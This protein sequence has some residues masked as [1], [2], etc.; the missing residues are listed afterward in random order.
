MITN[1]LWRLKFNK[2]QP[3]FHNPSKSIFMFRYK[4]LVITQPSL[5]TVLSVLVCSE[6]RSG[7]G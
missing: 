6:S 5:S 1:E 7:S 4:K 2:T 3:L